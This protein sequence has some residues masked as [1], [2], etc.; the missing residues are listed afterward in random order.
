MPLPLWLLIFSGVFL[1]VF[2]GVFFISRVG[3]GVVLGLTVS[4]ASL[5]A[6]CLYYP[7]AVPP[8]VLRF[9]TFIAFIV[10]IVH[11]ILQERYR[12]QLVFLPGF[13]RVANESAV[14]RSKSMKKPVTEVPPNMSL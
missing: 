1:A 5:V 9:A 8:A 14:T 7:A 13:Q 12:R 4:A 2:F 11:W 6:A 10:G 3:W